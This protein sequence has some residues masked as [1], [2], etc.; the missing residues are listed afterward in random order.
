MFEGKKNEIIA[1]IKNNKDSADKIIKCLCHAGE[2]HNVYY[3]YYRKLEI[4]EKII[5]S[6]SLILRNDN[7]NDIDDEENLKNPSDSYIKFA[8][9][10][11]YSNAE[12]VAMWYMYGGDLKTNV[13]VGY[14]KKTISNIIQN[15]Q[16]CLLSVGRLD[17]DFIKM[18]EIEEYDISISDVL[19]YDEMGQN[20]KVQR[21]NKNANID[22]STFID[23]PRHLL[24]HVSWNY[25]NECRIIVHVKKSLLKDGVN[26]IKLQIPEVEIEKIKKSIVKSPS[27]VKDKKNKYKASK[28]TNKI[29]FPKQTD[30]KSEENKINDE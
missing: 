25:E 6:K 16:H 9:C 8:L 2:H 5:N 7:Y 20:Y 28:L 23:V 14:S 11:T 26:A 3:I 4:V 30:E 13:R 17:S 19:Y 24:K 10:F 27:F 22:R 18:Q 15:N 21:G 1:D 12:S 29:I